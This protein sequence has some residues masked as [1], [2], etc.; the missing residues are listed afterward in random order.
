MPEGAHR[1]LPKQ[2]SETGL[3][4]LI[5]QVNAGN[6]RAFETLFNMYYQELVLYARTLVPSSDIAEGVVLDVFAKIWQQR[7]SWHPGAAL[8]SSLFARVRNECLSYLRTQQRRKRLLN[9]WKIYPL[10][11]KAPDNKYEAEE[12]AYFVNQAID[13]LPP[14]RKEI[15]NLS[16]HYG[17]TYKEIAALLDISTKTVESQMGKAIKFLRDQL[18][19]IL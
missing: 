1:M 2:Q 16:R 12:L 18:K 10:F 5:E 8:R 13:K 19:S 17:L 7:T 9:S 4:A 6:T 3:M 15:Y 11:E 14:R